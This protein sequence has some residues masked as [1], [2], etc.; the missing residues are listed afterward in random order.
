MIKVFDGSLDLINDCSAGFSS[1]RACRE[2]ALRPPEMSASNKQAQVLI[3][4]AE[5]QQVALQ[6]GPAAVAGYPDLT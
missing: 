1:E 6:Q 4:P 3:A 5:L 2:A